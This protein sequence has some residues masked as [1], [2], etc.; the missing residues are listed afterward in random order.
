MSYR[1]TTRWSPNYNAGGNTREGITI[2]HA[3][4]TNFASIG[5]RFDNPSEEASAHYGVEPGHVE[6]YVDE[7]NIAWHAGNSTANRTTIGIEVVNST[8]APDWNV[9]EASIDTLVE[10]VADIAKRNNMYPLVV[11]K[12]LFGHKDWSAT[13]CP[14]VLYPRLDEIARRA[15][16]MIKNGSSDGEWVEDKKGWWYKQKDGKYPKFQWKEIN[17]KWYYFDKEGYIKYGWQKINGKWYYLDPKNGDMKTGWLEDKGKWYYLDKTN[18]DM[19]TGWVKD[20]GK[21]YYMSPNSGDPLGSMLTGWQTIQSRLYYLD[22]KS[23]AMASGVTQSVNATKA[24]FDA[25]GHLT[26]LQ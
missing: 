13:F 15:N 17:G 9:A 1:F 10:L 26:K 20:K 22:P 6:Q 18:G 4:G 16:E 25:A 24:T 12:N 11:G 23:G 5:N 19:K 21:W 14:G 8:G 7:K 3:A 2:H